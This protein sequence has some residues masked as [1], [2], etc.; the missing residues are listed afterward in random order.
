MKRR[1][2]AEVKDQSGMLECWVT[3]KSSTGGAGSRASQEVIIL[4]CILIIGMSQEFPATSGDGQ[5]LGDRESPPSEF[6]SPGNV[7][8]T[9]PDEFQADSSRTWIRELW[10]QDVNGKFQDVDRR[11]R[12][13]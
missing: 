2:P 13:A 6:V 9:E 10:S 4:I 5:P 7:R 8:P 11:E 12:E 3:G 1:T